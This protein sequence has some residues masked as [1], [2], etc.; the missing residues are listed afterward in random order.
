M[1]SF[2]FFWIICLIISTLA[3][4]VSIYK[5]TEKFSAEKIIIMRSER[6]YSVG[7]IAFPAITICPEVTLTKN[8]YDYLDFG[9]T[10]LTEEE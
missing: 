3:F 1:F 9:S 6:P 10:N 8:I 7:E 4:L 5:L 2:R